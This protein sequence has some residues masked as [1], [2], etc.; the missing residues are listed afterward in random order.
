MPLAPRLSSLWRNL[1]SEAR[2]DREL[3]EEIDAKLEML[4]E[5]KV[6][7]GLDPEESRRAAMI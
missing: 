3:T 2:E 6:N 5:Q 7:D 1:F 4:V